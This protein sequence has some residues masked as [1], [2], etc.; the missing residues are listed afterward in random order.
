MDSTERTVLI[1]GGVGLGA[2][3]LFSFLKQTAANNL[4]AANQP[5]LEYQPSI[6][7]EPPS[8]LDSILS[9][10]S[11]GIQ[12]L[13]NLFGSFGAASTN[14]D[15]GLDTDPSIAYPGDN[16]TYSNSNSYTGLSTYDPGSVDGSASDASSASLFL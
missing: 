11:V 7:Y 8:T 14:N 1:V 15:P 10:A 2:I 6:P 12:S 13:G 16:Y 9:G 5:G 3:L 4:A